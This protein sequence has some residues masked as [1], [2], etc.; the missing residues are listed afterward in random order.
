MSTRLIGAAVLAVAT[1]S[2]LVATTPHAVAAEPCTPSISLAKPTMSGGFDTY[3]VS[4]VTCDGPLLITLKHQQ[5]GT[6]DK[7]IWTSKS[8]FSVGPNSSGQVTSRH[9]CIPDALSHR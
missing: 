9:V 4:Y 2:V 5:K 3:T 8:H 1:T 6:A 7:N